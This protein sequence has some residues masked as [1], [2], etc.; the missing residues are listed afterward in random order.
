MVF[1]INN[2]ESRLFS[3]KRIIAKN[4]GSVVC[5]F[6]SSNLFINIFIIVKI[7]ILG[8]ININI[9][10][11]LFIKSLNFVNIFTFCIIMKIVDLGFIN[12]KNLFIMTSYFYN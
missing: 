12:K 1:Q 9:Y 10:I 7:I 2:N 4:A 5:L 11:Y 8:F 6:N 3:E